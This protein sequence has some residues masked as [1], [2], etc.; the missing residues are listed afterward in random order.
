MFVDAPIL[1][2]CDIIDLPGFGT[3]TESDDNI[4][5][6]TTQ[7]ADIIIYLSQ[8]NGF[9]RIEDIT[10]LKRNISELP[11]WESRGKNALKPLA[12]LFVVASQ[13][14]AVD[15]GNAENLGGILEAGCTRLLA[16]LSPSYWDNRKRASGYID[17]KYGKNELFSRFFA[18][19][20]DIPHLCER[21]N[22]SL[23]TVLEILPLV[24]ND[25]AKRFV[26]EYVKSRKPNLQAE[27]EK[28]ELV[29]AERDKYAML[30]AE[31]D[32]NEW[33]R[34][35][36]NS[37][38][39]QD[40]RLEISS[41]RDKSILEFGNYCSEQINTDAIVSLIKTRKIKNK[42]EEIECFGSSLQTM[43]QEKCETIL[44]QNS[45][46]LS[47]KIKYYISD[48]SASIDKSFEKSD[49]HSDFDVG[50]AF[51]SALAKFGM[52]GGLAGYL[53]GSA[54]IAL[55][56][57]TFVLGAGGTA[58]AIVSFLGPYG[59]AAGLVITA[60][61]GILN[62]FGRGWK[63]NVAKKLV[64]AFEKN[65][66]AGKLR[67]GIYEY[68]AQTQVAFDRTAEELDNEWSNYVKT[69]RET[70]VSYDINEIQRKIASLKSLTLFFDNIPL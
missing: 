61:L 16:A 68:W 22:S 34:V 67:N 52:I 53:A 60:A 49:V 46:S 26:A 9:M 29:I 35:H 27:L 25:R 37:K 42:K 70:V 12:N 4:T 32:K 58:A 40:V 19:T 48:F 57:I 36:D 20:T 56:G 62:L 38:R 1:N 6:K 43:L 18:Y 21:F 65:D 63:K 28:Y 15:S 17:D 2:T 30:L 8:A 64:E 66:I 3:G 24:I 50:W 54:A 31:I 33:T 10:Y 39:K 55:G 11:I 44:A 45:E 23:K 47:E 7:R 5:F 69:L 59:F 13:A 14:H 41:L 51:A